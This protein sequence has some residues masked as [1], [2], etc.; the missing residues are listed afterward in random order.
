MQNYV[1]VL[2]FLYWNGVY[3]SKQLGTSCKKKKGSEINW[4]AFFSV[5]C[6]MLITAKALKVCTS[7]KEQL[8]QKRQSCYYLGGSH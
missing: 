8:L 5:L 1:G 6:Y 7:F 4:H 2:D 3:K